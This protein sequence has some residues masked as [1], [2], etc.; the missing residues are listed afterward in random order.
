MSDHPDQESRNIREINAH[1]DKIA[2]VQGYS[3]GI[4]WELHLRAYKRYCELYGEQ[5]ALID[6]R[7]RNCRGGFHVNELDIFIPNWREEL[8]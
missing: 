2:P 8:K 6:L 1:G 7:G 3:P 5:H 4:P